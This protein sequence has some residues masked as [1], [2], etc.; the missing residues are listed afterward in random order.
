MPITTILDDDENHRKAQEFFARGKLVA[1]T[2]NLEYAIEMYMQGVAFDPDNIDAHQALREISLR[3]KAGGG[4]EL[5]LLERMKL[6]R[7]DDDEKLNM[8]NAEKMLAY[9]PGNRQH[10]AAM[11]QAARAARLSATTA[12]IEAI[13]KQASG[14]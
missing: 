8:L 5:N 3:R 4:K 11:V 13:R 1:G 2:G 9:D 6:G 14:K 12:W 7:K 10:M